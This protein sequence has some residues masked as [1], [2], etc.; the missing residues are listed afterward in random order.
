MPSS[1]GPEWQQIALYAV[2]AAVLLVLLQRIPF[3]GRIIR[4]ALSVGLLAVCLYLLLQQAPYEPTLGRIAGSLGLDRQEVVGKEVRI[5]MAADGHFWAR[6]T[7]NGAERRMLI[8]SGATVTAI[9]DRTAQAA[10]ID[11]GAGM[12]P[13]LMRTAN[14]VVQARTG[15]IDEMRLG[16]VTA[17]R[18]KVVISPALGGLDVLGMNFLSKLAS[19]RVE[20]KTLVLVPHHP[21]PSSDGARNA[22]PDR[23]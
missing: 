2:G 9:S 18:L 10:G 23:A 11:S 12:V 6:V 13:V 7:L 20:G 21:Q 17:R 19:W 14:G 8:D 16:N 5:R 1:I 3:V 22:S 15:T 4:F